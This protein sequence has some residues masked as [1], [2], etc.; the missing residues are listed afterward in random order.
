MLSR[1][2]LSLPQ[3]FEG[4]E[5]LCSYYYP[6]LCTLALSIT[7][8]NGTFYR[9]N[10]QYYSS[11]KPL[12]WHLTDISAR[13]EV[14]PQKP[15][16]YNYSRDARNLWEQKIVSRPITTSYKQLINWDRHQFRSLYSQKCDKVLGITDTM[17]QEVEILDN[18]ISRLFH[19]KFLFFS[20]GLT[21]LRLLERLLP[22][23]REII[24]AIWQCVYTETTDRIWSVYDFDLSVMTQARKQKEW[25]PSDV[26]LK[27][28]VIH[29]GTPGRPPLQLLKPVIKSFPVVLLK[30]EST[31]IPQ[32][33]EVDSM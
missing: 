20:L 13:G 25:I 30:D 11:L 26:F 9:G 24:R 17:T 15:S 29:E 5:E 23:P 2:Q 12:H 21:V 16:E 31:F 33:E 6:P 8:K 14:P 3:P 22:L 10:R 18:H 28:P 32:V 7:P 19:S 4:A 27:R 1:H